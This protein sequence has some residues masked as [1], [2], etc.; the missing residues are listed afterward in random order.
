MRT[1]IPVK[2]RDLTRKIIDITLLVFFFINII[3]I[4]YM[5]DIEQLVVS[6]ADHTTNWP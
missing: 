6:G 2:D 3:F 4:C 5:F 1:A